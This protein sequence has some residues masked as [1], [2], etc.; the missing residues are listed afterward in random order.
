[1]TAPLETVSDL[2]HRLGLELTPAVRSRMHALIT[3][4]IG[5]DHTRHRY[6]LEQFGFDRAT[7]ER[8]FAPYR[9]RFSE[10]I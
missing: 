6:T 1:M 5:G 7:I 10:L 8:V 9:E 2:Y 3:T 4:Q